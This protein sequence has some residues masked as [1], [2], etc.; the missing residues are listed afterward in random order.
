MP[1]IDAAMKGHLL[2]VGMHA[3]SRYSLCCPDTALFANCPDALTKRA[4]HN[5]GEEHNRVSFL[6]GRELCNKTRTAHGMLSLTC[7]SRRWC[8]SMSL[9]LALQSPAWTLCILLVDNC[10]RLQEALLVGLP[11]DGRQHGGSLFRRTRQDMRGS[12]LLWCMGRRMDMGRR[13]STGSQLRCCCRCLDR[14][15]CWCLE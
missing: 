8:C 6:E 10:H 13:R 4:K 1:S 12:S 5:E 14:R 15:W 7:S 2:S 9:D 11:R 3:T